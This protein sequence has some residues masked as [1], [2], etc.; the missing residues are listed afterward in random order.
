VRGDVYPAFFRTFSNNSR[1]NEFVEFI[2]S[3]HDL[4]ASGILN[5][6]NIDESQLLTEGDLRFIIVPNNDY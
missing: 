1:L 3:T 2:F 4:I 6:N 5:Q